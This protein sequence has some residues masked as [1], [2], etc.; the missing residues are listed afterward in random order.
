VDT[1]C[2][3]VRDGVTVPGQP[4]QIWSCSSG[5]QQMFQMVDVENS[6]TFHSYQL[7]PVYNHWCVNVH[8]LY[9]LA[10]LVEQPCGT[11]TGYQD[12][13]TLSY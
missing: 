8:D 3:D 7:R 6:S 12:R 2:V 1:K 4:L 9:P 10:Q 5:W 13:W 11:G